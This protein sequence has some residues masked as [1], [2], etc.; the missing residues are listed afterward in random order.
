MSSYAV[1]VVSTLKSPDGMPYTVPLGKNTILIGDNESGKSAIAESL[2]LARTGSAF[3]LLYRDKPVKAGTLLSA[4]IPLGADNAQASALLESGE[5][6]TWNLKRGSSTK[7]EGPVGTS[8]SIAEL[9]A[10]M[11]ASLETKVK[12]FWERIFWK[13]EYQ[14]LFDQL[15]PPMQEALL[16][17][18]PV[19]KPVDLSELLGKIGK[20]Q[21][22]QSNTVKAGQIALESLGSVRKFSDD[23]LRGVWDTMNRGLI[24][25][26]VKVMYRDN[27][28]DPS[29]QLGAGIDYLIDYLGGKDALRRVGSTEE[30]GAD[31]SEILLHRRLNRA[32]VAAKNGEIRAGD[33]RESLKALRTAILNVMI[34]AV[35]AA[36]DEF[37]RK[38]SAFLPKEEGFIFEPGSPGF[39]IGLSREEE[40]HTALSGSTEARLL[41]AIAAGLSDESDLIIVDD[42]MWDPATLRRTM[43]ALEKAPAQVVIMS[44]IEPKGRKRGAW[45]YVKVS[46]ES[47]EPLDI[48]NISK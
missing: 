19:G 28:S 27:K 8:L 4:L 10:V 7:Q 26:I 34:A 39:P 29:L 23:E 18:C 9:H 24:R 3:G 16:L 43:I 25:D 15:E 37:I 21:R 13:I 44:T 31:L 14:E 45:T 5:T 41:A 22:E 6:C 32:A 46:R 40:T 1:E 47:G 20:L 33:L 17:V 38:I 11:A 36:S 35:S 30:A 12:F 2:Q 48:E 42:R